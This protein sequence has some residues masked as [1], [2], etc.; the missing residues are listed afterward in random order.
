MKT[1][2]NEYLTVRLLELV[3]Q[4]IPFY[5]QQ[6]FSSGQSCMCPMILA[7]LG[8]DQLLAILCIVFR[9]FVERMAGI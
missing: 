2:M 7:V 1:K 8:Q 3:R 4:S 9:R 5:F 6:F